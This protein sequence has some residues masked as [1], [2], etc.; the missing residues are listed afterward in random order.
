MNNKKNKTELEI[1]IDAETLS[2]I[3][4]ISKQNGM[5][6]NNYII[7]LIDD[8]ISEFEKEHSDIAINSKKQLII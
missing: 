6:L 2:K 8:Y 4:Y 5:I 1:P 7:S 3:Q